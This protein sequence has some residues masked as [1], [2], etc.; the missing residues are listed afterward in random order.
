MENA[1]VYLLLG[2]NQGDCAETFSRARKEIADSVGTIVTASSL[3]SSPAWGFESTQDFLNQVLCVDTTRNPYDLLYQVQRIEKAL[4]RV[5]AP[6]SLGMTPQEKR[7]AGLYTSRTIDIDILFYDDA[8]IRSKEL[9]I[10]H[11]L[12]QERAFTMVPLAEIAP[13][14]VHPLLGKTMEEL[15]RLCPDRVAEVRLCE[16]SSAT[17]PIEM[18]LS[19]SGQGNMEF[20][21][22]L[23]F[24]AI[25][26]NIGAGKTSL[27]R[28][29]SRQFGARLVVERFEDNVFLPKFYQDRERFAFPLELSFLAERYRQA[30]EDFVQDLFSPFIVSDFTI[31][32]SL[33]FSQNNLQPDEYD[34]FSRL[35]HIV[36]GS[37][38]KPDIYVY[39]HS[40]VERL[41]QNINQRGRSYEMDMDPAYL[42]ML[43]EGYFKYIK[44]LPAEKTLVL[45]VTGLDFVHRQ[46]HYQYILSEIIRASLGI[47][48]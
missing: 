7:D 41:L 46:D 8:I 42:K 2:A 14:L 36:L 15:C 32:K 12:L 13:D 20:P 17:D 6:Q 21:S 39:L 22:S 10:P 4:G 43:E 26:G 30:K 33:V 29:I 31:A 11:P 1:R 38:P 24:L 19:T 27:A 35:F 9:Q 40:D 28:L 3:Y 37:V 44:T 5:R 23:R 48:N 25:E 16:P 45:D 18:A 47:K 34:L